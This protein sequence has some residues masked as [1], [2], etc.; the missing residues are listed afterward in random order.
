M[1]R[2]GIT[3][4]ADFRKKS[5][6]QF[7]TIQKHNEFTQWEAQISFQVLSQTAGYFKARKKK[8]SAQIA[9]M[10]DLMQTT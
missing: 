2:C 5:E 6:N 3:G 4:S 10:E 9:P 1:E 8:I 7:P